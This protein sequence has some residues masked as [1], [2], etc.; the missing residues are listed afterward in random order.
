MGQDTFVE[1]LFKGKIY[2]LWG[3]TDSPF[4]PLSNFAT[5]GATSLLPWEGGVDPEIGVELNYFVND[6]VFSKNMCPF[7]LFHLTE[8]YEG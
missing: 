3:D 7:L 8:N 4:Y 6:K 2:W 5:S 1:T